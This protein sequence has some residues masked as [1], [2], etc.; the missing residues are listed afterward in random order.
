MGKLRRFWDWLLPGLV[1][2]CP[3]GAMAYYNTAAEAP[4][5]HLDSERAGRRSLVSNSL[6]VAA[7]IPAARI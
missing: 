1:Y 4:A 3:M 6:L 5:A 7:I 2:L